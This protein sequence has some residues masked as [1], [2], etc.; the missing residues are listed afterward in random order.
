MSQENLQ[1]WHEGDKSKQGWQK[2]ASK[3]LISH[4]CVQTLDMHAGTGIVRAVSRHL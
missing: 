4:L 2:A 1:R 3:G